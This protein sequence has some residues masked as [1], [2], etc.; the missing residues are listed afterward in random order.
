MRAVQAVPAVP[1][2]T[3]VLAVRAVRAVT[4]VHAKTHG[5]AR[6]VSIP[7]AAFRLA[8]R[9]PRFISARA[10]VGVAAWKY[11]VRVRVRVR[12]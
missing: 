10:D 7:P 3:V 6:R 8:G 12:T 9:E 2:M 11:L 5:M 1:A 4:C